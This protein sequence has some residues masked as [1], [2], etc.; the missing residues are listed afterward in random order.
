MSPFE[1]PPRK[2]FS[3]LRKLFSIRTRIFFEVHNSKACRKVCGR[4]T[5]TFTFGKG[6]K[7]VN[8]SKR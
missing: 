8:V 2:L 7:I 4:K 3:V 5:N 6:F 1:T